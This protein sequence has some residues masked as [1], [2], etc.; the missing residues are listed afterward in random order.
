MISVFRTISFWPFLTVI[1]LQTINHNRSANIRH[2]HLDK[3]VL[4]VGVR[5]DIAL[6]TNRAQIQTIGT[7][8]FPCC[9]VVADPCGV[10]R[11]VCHD[12]GSALRDRL[13]TAVCGARS[14]KRRNM[15]GRISRSVDG[16][17]SA[18]Y[19]YCLPHY[20]TQVLYD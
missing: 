15:A 11:E 5:V 2:E 7:I 16:V 4:K 13:E 20:S 8:I 19:V 12:V 1:L 9:V 3:W 6:I 17:V 10:S 14:R 18:L